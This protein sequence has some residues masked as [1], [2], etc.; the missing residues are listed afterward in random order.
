M[1]SRLRGNDRFPFPQH[2]NLA[3]LAAMGHVS[4]KQIVTTIMNPFLSAS[5][6]VANLRH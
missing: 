5:L 2:E 4:V 3:C 6:N 1:D